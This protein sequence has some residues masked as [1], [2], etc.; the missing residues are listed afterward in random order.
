MK[1]RAMLYRLLSGSALVSESA[2]KEGSDRRGGDGPVACELPCWTS[3]FTQ[4]EPTQSG[5]QIVG[6]VLD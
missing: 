4:T 5:E 2:G 6:G 1:A 3:R